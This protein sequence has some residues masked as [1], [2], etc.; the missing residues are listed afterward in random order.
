MLAPP[1]SLCL[2]SPNSALWDCLTSKQYRN[3]RTSNRHMF[4]LKAG[5]LHSK[6]C[7]GRAGIFL[8]EENRAVHQLQA[9]DGSLLL[10]EHPD[11]LGAA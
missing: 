8:L 9:P 7:D 11:I 4:P 10:K 3:I 5:R 6:P 1:T 2:Y